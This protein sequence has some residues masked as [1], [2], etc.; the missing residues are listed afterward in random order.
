M[1][2][3]TYNQYQSDRSPRDDQS[4]AKDHKQCEYGANNPVLPSRIEKTQI[5]R[6]DF[7]SLNALANYLFG[8]SANMLSKHS[9]AVLS[10]A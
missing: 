10:L 4:K 5:L 9:T 2:E 1:L 6:I 8:R 3:F 7:N